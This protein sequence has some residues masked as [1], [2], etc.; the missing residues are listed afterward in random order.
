MR[1]ATPFEQAS[2]QVALITQAQDSMIIK[3]KTAW[4]LQIGG[5]LI[6]VTATNS[7]FV[8]VKDMGLS[9]W[10]NTSTF[11]QDLAN[12]H[13]GHPMNLIGYVMN[14]RCN[15][16]ALFER[17]FLIKWPK[18]FPG[19]RKT[20]RTILHWPFKTWYTK[21]TIHTPFQWRCLREFADAF[22][23]CGYSNQKFD[24]LFA[25]A[26][27]CDFVCVSH[28]RIRRPMTFNH[29]SFATCWK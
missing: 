20:K 28:C 13:Q 4:I 15:T 11:T 23:K 21:R 8:T 16:I 2:R 6:L 29:L 10:T 9:E 7:M 18:T 24:T 14:Y 22:Q 17:R 25:D 12:L 3:H 19:L 5:I 27:W 1:S 26:N